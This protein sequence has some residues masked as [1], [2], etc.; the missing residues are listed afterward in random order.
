MWYPDGN[1]QQLRLARLEDGQWHV[2]A[3]AE[4]P[5]DEGKI[6]MPRMFFKEG[7]EAIV[8]WQDLFPP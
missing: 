8:V 7:G 1:R 3:V 2:T 4:Q 6:F 5:K